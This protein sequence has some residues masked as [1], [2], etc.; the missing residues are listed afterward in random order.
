MAN[1]NRTG[2]V[3]IHCTHGHTVYFLPRDAMH[4]RGLC[5]R[6]VAGCMSVTFVHCLKTAKDTAIVAMECK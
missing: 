4:K 5:R 6:P 2:S 1:Q 3:H